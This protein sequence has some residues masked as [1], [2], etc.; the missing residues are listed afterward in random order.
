V[1]SN[2]QNAVAIANAF[3][4]ANDPTALRDVFLTYV[5][6]SENDCWVWT[7]NYTTR[8]RMRT[9][10]TVYT[11]VF[12]P[13]KL[14]DPPTRDARRYIYRTD[15]NPT[16]SLYTHLTL[17]PTCHPLCVNPDHIMIRGRPTVQGDET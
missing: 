9:G 6:E 15:I 14:A 1:N 8:Y 2:A 10:D 5:E 3:R 4:M 16:L 13:G 11:P 12:G 17:K 7:G